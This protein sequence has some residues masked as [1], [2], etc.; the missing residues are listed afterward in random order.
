MFSCF[1]VTSLFNSVQNCHPTHPHR[2]APAEHFQNY[3][4]KLPPTYCSVV[5]VVAPLLGK[6]VLPAKRTGGRFSY[7]ARKSSVFC[8]FCKTR[9]RLYSA[10]FSSF[11]L[12]SRTCCVWSIDRCVSISFPPAY[13]FS[14]S[15]LERILF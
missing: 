3:H 1:F 2:P 5:I 9:S 4:P 10:L 8:S 15:E 12:L 7:S 14:N 6:P 11:V 13:V